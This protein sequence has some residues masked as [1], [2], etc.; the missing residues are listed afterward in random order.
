[1]VRL[2]IL[3]LCILIASL[4]SL[5]AQRGNPVTPA[6]G[7]SLLFDVDPVLQQLAG[8]ID[9]SRLIASLQR[10]EAFRTR[11]SSTDSL[12]AAKNWLVTK[13]QE[14]GYSDVLQHNFTW[15]SRTLQN[16]VVTK[17]GTRF[18]NTYVL[19]IGHY[20][21][22]SETPTSLAPGVNDNGS[23]IALILEV[24]RLLA[25]KNL[26]YSVR[27]IC[28]SAEEQGLVGSR[29]YVQNVVVP[30]NHNI[31]IVINVDE[32]GG[33]RGNANTMV[34]VERDEDNSPS[35]NN[36]ASARYTDTLAAITRTY[37]TLTTT[38]T[39]AYGSD[40]MSFEDAGYVI[41]GYYEGI[42]TPHYHRS[43][44]NF[45]NVDPQYLYQIT[46]GAIA[47]VAHFAG[48]QRKYLNILH[49]PHGDTQDSSRNI[50][51][52]AQLLTSAPILQGQV[53][54]RT[55]THPAYSAVPMSQVGSAGDSL[56]YRGFIPKQPYGTTVSYFLKFANGDTVL[57]TFPADTT[58]PIV[59]HVAGD[60]VPPAI[61]HSALS[62][63]SY[64]D[65]P[66]EIRATITDQNSISLAW[67]EYKANGGTLRLDTMEQV[68]GN[69]WR[70]YIRG[71]FTP[72]DR[73]EYA[74]Y[75]KDGS[76][77]GNLAKLPEAGWFSWR[78]LNS[79]LL[80]FENS[81]GGFEGSGDWSWGL[82]GTTDIPA[83]PRGQR[84]WATNLG[85]NYANNLNSVLESPPFDLSNKAEGV[86]TFTHLYRIEPN[87]DGGNF[88]VS[89]DSGAFQL[90][91]PQG[92]Y[93]FSSIVALGGPGYS[94]N[95]TGWVEAGFP[96]STFT[97]HRVRFRFRF[98]SDWLT[99]HRGW[100][101][102]E[103]RVD[104]LDSVTVGTQPDNLQLPAQTSLGHGY[105]NPF[106]PKTNI[107]FSVD[108][109]GGR[110]RITVFDLLGREV[111]T[112]VNDYKPVGFYTVEWNASAAS[113][114]IYIV[115]MD[116]TQQEGGG[117]PV[118]ARKLILMK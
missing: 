54:F 97:N 29:A 34:K 60:S 48:I 3:S 103:M 39:N 87:N 96:L 70:G 15:S 82:I 98:S 4:Q 118:A 116:V 19:L 36:E 92:N 57:S 17:T 76:F 14:Y 50:Q 35:S 46:R 49:S 40:Y 102:D 68:S 13:F 53:F 106:N 91:T 88:W 52:D 43:T 22:I 112:L 8:A 93:P 26:D 56:L 105:P 84:V 78:V 55:N 2:Y 61:T 38:I 101:I 5:H 100:Y 33:Y 30:E 12:V 86:L 10:L 67:I 115:R 81:N 94:G 75:A 6:E 64:L 23:G 44:D 16:I 83:P 1:M 21:S 65:N 42:E 99:N 95:S 31:K 59:F 109:R 114:G 111:T 58:S 37:S 32:I 25:S 104:Y 89:V 74:I 7:P 71:P 90:M 24:A 108:S 79:I 47:G 62:N 20:D 18:P 107:P 9:S 45:A 73:I 117:S 27:F 85:G 110:V 80:D 69:M 113:S 28:F 11:H 66:Y 72:G 63:K 51:L 41:T 77:S